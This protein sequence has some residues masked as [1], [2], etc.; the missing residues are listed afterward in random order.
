[1]TRVRSNARSSSASARGAQRGVAAIEFALVFV[2]LFS[3]LYALA[4]FGAVLYTQ[5]AV[6]R[7]AEEGARAVGLLTTP[8]ATVG[9]ARIKD[10]VYDALA[11]S[12]VVPVS[13]NANAASRRSWIVSQ[14]TVDVTSAAP[15]SPGA[16]VN[17]IVTV[18]Y[19]Y[20]ANRLLPSMMVLDTSRWMPDQLRSRASAALW[21]S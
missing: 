19:P 10:A 16:Y 12:L 13:A 3:V 17:Y 21:T 6:T 5:Q 1:M 7:A 14:V 15:G 8:T 18:T 20:S 9:D 4:T 11:N 2:I